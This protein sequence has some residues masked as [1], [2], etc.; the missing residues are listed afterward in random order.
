ML[1]LGTIVQD[2]YRIV[3][4]LGQ[5]GMGAVYRAWDLRLKVPVA[6]KELRPQPGLNVE[7]LAALR[8]QFEQEA[9]VLAR[10]NHPNLVRVTDF[11]EESGNAYLVMD[12]VEGRTLAEMITED[13]AQPESQVLA[14]AYQLLGALDYCHSQGVIHRDIKPQNI[15]IKADGRAILVDFGL[16]KLWDPHDPRTRTA[17]RGMGTPEYAP[18]EQYGVT[19]DHTGPASDLYSL[20]A[21]LYHALTGQAPPTVT[22]RMAMP[23]HFLPLHQLAP[24]V[25]RRTEEA[26]MGALSLSVHSRWPSA[27][28]MLA[29]LSS[30]PLPATRV[31]ASAAEADEEPDVP[32][33]V[34]PQTVVARQPV[35]PAQVITP[36][37]EPQAYGAVSTAGMAPARKKRLWLPI[38]A[39]VLLCGIVGCLGA[40]VLRPMIADWFGPAE[41]EPTT[42]VTSDASVNATET[43]DVEPD[44]GATAT[45]ASA[46]PDSTDF[47]I[48]LDNQSPYDVCYVYVSPSDSND[49]G[50]DWLGTE[51][52]IGPGQRR[53]FEV[54]AGIYDCIARTCDGATLA[55]AWD[56]AADHTL[57]I[58]GGDLVPLRVTN[59]LDVKVCYVH[60]SPVTSDDWGLDMLGSVEALPAGET[61]I[62]FVSP[63]TYDMLAQDCEMNDL[64]DRY[65]IAIEEESTWEI[66]SDEP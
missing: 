66:S 9:S 27:E 19:D 41:P 52:V 48:E 58:G 29:A 13:G 10:L 24:H 55:T 57:L 5:G 54:P 4:P 36:Q 59:S 42:T 26:I 63:G 39:G 47:V 61:R 14:W 60:V 7:M 43:A 3:K 46:G 30:G 31:M 20:G 8:E 65:G 6:L 23:E 64:D 11:F 1:Q 12:F 34:L 18:P 56:V 51:E 49:W 16:V 45:P 28:A 44:E 33:P 21:T 17:M 22:E 2:R 25:S 53:S 50:N 38:L 15:V 32:P 37:T 62:L 35:V 40:V